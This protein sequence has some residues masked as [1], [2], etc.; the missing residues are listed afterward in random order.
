MLAAWI[1]DRIH[2]IISPHDTDRHAAQTSAYWR[3]YFHANAEAVREV[4]W[5]DGAQITSEELAE[6]VDSLR[7]W[8]LLSARNRK[9]GITPPSERPP[10]RCSRNPRRAHAP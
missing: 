7:A 4:P 1:K 9:R 2:S 6:I 8:Q 3:D 10:S 5:E